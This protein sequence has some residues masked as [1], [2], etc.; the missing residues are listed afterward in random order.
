MKVLKIDNNC[1][2]YL[3]SENDYT[4]VKDINKDDIYYILKMII[5]IDDIDDIEIDIEDDNIL[6]INNEAEKIVYNS[7]REEIEKV[8]DEKNNLKLEIETLFKEAYEKYSDD[9]IWDVVIIKT[10]FKD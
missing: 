8:I 10:E 3:N 9:L 4:S 5:D 1:G 2:M 7:L 6:K